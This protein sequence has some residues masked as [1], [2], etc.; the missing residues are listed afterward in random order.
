MKGQG[1]WS[2]AF[3]QFQVAIRFGPELAPPHNNLGELRAYKGWLDE[4]IAQYRQALRLDPEFGR[5]EYMLGV[6]LAARGRLD[7]ANDRDQR[8]VRDDPVRA[9]AQKKTRLIAVDQGIINYQRP[10]D[11]PERCALPRRPW[12]RPGRCG[13]AERGDRPLREC[14]AD[15]TVA[16]VSARGTGPSAHGPGAISRGLDRDPPLP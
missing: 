7:E 10:R 5:A 3:H 4:A 12:P 15:R 1:K 8:A 2:E 6:A 14:R 11:R 9:E 16:L 13:P